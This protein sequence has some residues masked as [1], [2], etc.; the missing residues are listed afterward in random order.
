MSET[1]VPKPLS[2]Q[3]AILERS[4]EGS[5]ARVA[6]LVADGNAANADQVGLRHRAEAAETKVV[7]S[8]ARE[9]MLKVDAAEW[10]GQRDALWSRAKDAEQEVGVER[11]RAE[12]AEA[13]TVSLQKQIEDFEAALNELVRILDGGGNDSVS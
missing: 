7:E 5:R 10:A 8:L 13:E 4:V 11:A 2:E 6:R 1:G 3:V 12:R 9:E